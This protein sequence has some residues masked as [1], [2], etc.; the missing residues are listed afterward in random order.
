MSAT[1]IL[2]IVGIVVSV[3]LFGLGERRYGK[4]FRAERRERADEREQ[5]RYRRAR[6]AEKQSWQSEFEEIRGYQLRAEAIADR[7]LAQA[8]TSRALADDRELEELEQRYE[9]VSKR[10]PEEL[11]PSLRIV[12][13]A[14]RRL[15]AIKLPTDRRV[16]TAYEQALSHGGLE[17]LG[18]EWLA[19][20]M[21]AKVLEHHDAASGFREAIGAVWV[22]LRKARGEE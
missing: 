7:I 8:N 22:E 12:S 9:A 20:T 3:T 15:R 6:A 16:K 18:S 14:I 4:R 21:G 17:A 19:S 1:M 11:A 13:E 5:E 2:G 10:C